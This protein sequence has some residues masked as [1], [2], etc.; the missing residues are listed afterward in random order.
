VNR[1]AFVESGSAWYLQQSHRFQTD[2]KK[3]TSQRMLRAWQ[4]KIGRLTS[5]L[6]MLNISFT[7]SLIGNLK[8][9]QVWCAADGKSTTSAESS[10]GSDSDRGDSGGGSG[11][12]DLGTALSG[13]L[14]MTASSVPF[15]DGN[16][17]AT[18]QSSGSLGCW[19]HTCRTNLDS[20]A[21]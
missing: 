1:R 8:A 10:A 21:I 3:R 6:R 7:V 20:R 12:L 19:N 16:G 9:P 5:G 2:C 13:C 15:I 14:S 18:P 4:K 11:Q 17:C